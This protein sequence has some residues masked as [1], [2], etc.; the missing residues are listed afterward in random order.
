MSDH[1]ESEVQKFV[2]Q[3]NGD[4]LT[5]KIVYGMLKA[6]DSDAVARHEETVCV[7]NKHLIE[8][9]L[10]DQR[11][12][13]HDQ[14]IRDIRIGANKNA[15]SAANP[16]ELRTIAAETARDLVRTAA[17]VAVE[18]VHTAEAVAKDLADT[19]E[20]GDM[21]RAWRVGK[22]IVAGV[23]IVLFNQLGNMWLGR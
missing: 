9:A 8:S 17:T 3:Q 11:L 1:F 15:G 6:V 20:E 10:R 18:T 13:D 22:W 16:S 12:L 7:L 21:K 4:D 19:P 14:A 23:G 5:P 2:G